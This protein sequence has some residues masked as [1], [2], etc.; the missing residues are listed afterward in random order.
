MVVLSYHDVVIN[1]D[2]RITYDVN[3]HEIIFIFWVFFGFVS[4][5]FDSLNLNNVLCHLCIYIF[6]FLSSFLKCFVVEVY[7]CRFTAHNTLQIFTCSK[8]TLETPGK[9]V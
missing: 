3:F 8:S 2:Y 1:L 5:L 9:G 7:F 6:P 4:K